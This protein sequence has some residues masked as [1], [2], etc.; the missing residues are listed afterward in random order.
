MHL[1][2]KKDFEELFECL[3]LFDLVIQRA[4]YSNHLNSP[5]NAL[6]QMISKINR[7][8]DKHN[9]NEGKNE[10]NNYVFILSIIRNLLRHFS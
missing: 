5:I 7:F 9:I 8:Y 2:E 4:V 1:L 6:V 10:E 3:I